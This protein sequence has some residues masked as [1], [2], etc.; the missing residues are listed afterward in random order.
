MTRKHPKSEIVN[1]R[2]SMVDA[3]ALRGQAHIAG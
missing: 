1:V 3:E 2:T